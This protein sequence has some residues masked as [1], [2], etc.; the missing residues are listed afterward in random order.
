MENEWRVDPIS[1]GSRQTGSAQLKFEK[2]HTFWVAG[3]IL[4]WIFVDELDIGGYRMYYNTC[5]DADN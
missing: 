3:G 1:G 5:E 2:G 4:A